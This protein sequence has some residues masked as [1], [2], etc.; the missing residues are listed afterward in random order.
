MKSIRLTLCLFALSAATLTACDKDKTTT[1]KHA[2]VT[3]QA[4]KAINVNLTYDRNIDVT[5]K[6]I[7]IV[8]NNVAPW[9][10]SMFIIDDNNTLRRGPIDGGDFDEVA[11]N[12]SGMAPLARKTRQA[13]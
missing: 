13:L 5:V 8:P 9:L 6:D 3:T 4:D 7:A 11:Q 1:D 12:I 2:P 10:G